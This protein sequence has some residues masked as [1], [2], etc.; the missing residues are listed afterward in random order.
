MKLIL[1]NNKEVGSPQPTELEEFTGA[2]RGA[3]NRVCTTLMS[4]DKRQNSTWILLLCPQKIGGAAAPL[5]P[6]VPPPLSLE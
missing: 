1:E 6:Y 4:H 3:E 5:A 2:A